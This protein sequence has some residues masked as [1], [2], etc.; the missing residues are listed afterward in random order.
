MQAW[1]LQKPALENYSVH[2]EYDYFNK[3]DAVVL[4][5]VDDTFYLFPT[6]VK[7]IVTKIH[8]AV[9]EIFKKLKEKCF[10]LSDILNK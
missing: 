4:S 3:G 5:T 1:L 10:K 8:F 9:E 7:N 2:I 6:E